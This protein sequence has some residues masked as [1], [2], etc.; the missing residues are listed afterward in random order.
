MNLIPYQP[1]YLAKL[2]VFRSL[3][4]EGLKEKAA[5]AK[6][7]EA[8]CTITDLVA[9]EFPELLA[10]ITRLRLEIRLETKGIPTTEALDAASAQPILTSDPNYNEQQFNAFQE[11]LKRTWRKLAPLIHPDRGG[12]KEVF[13]DAYKA[14]DLQRLTD[15]YMRIKVVSNL[16]WQQ[17]EEGMA[18]ASTELERSK[19][20]HQAIRASPVFMVVQNHLSGNVQRAR[21]IMEI[22]LRQEILKLLNEITYLRTK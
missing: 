8:I 21:H 12:S 2:Y 15:I 19:V 7:Y 13:Q 1:I 18:Y 6:T 20:Q 11:M 16:Y 17:S 4:K 9:K 3:Y 14:R 10:E 5:Y 22:H